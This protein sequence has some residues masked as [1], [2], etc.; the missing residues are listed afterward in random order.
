MWDDK[1]CQDMPVFVHSF[2][3]FRRFSVYISTSYTRWYQCSQIWFSA[4]QEGFAIKG[5]LF[6]KVSNFPRNPRDSVKADER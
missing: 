5:R 1:L 3:A 2:A 4:F 6:P